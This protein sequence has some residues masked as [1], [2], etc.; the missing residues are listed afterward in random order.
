M[1]IKPRTKLL[2]DQTVADAL[3]DALSSSLYVVFSVQEVECARRCGDLE[4][5]RVVKVSGPQ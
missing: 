1:V 5:L 3:G 4:D 2:N